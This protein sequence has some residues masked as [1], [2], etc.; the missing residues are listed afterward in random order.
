MVKNTM[1]SHPEINSVGW[2]GAEYYN[3]LGYVPC[4]AGINEN[5]V[6][7]LEYAYADFCLARLAKELG[8][9]DAEVEKYEKRA[10]N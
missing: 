1:G 7:T 2:Y 10:M 3:E 4:D 8:K 6:T 5:A 9:P